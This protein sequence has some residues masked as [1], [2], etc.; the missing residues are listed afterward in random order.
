[1]QIAWQMQCLERER[2][3]RGKPVTLGWC[4]D[5]IVSEL[6]VQIRFGGLACR[7]RGRRSAL[8]LVVQ[9][10]WQGLDFRARRADFVGAVLWRMGRSALGTVGQSLPLPNSSPRQLRRVAVKASRE[11]GPCCLRRRHRGAS[12]QSAR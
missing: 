7:C 11:K 8:E 9:M 3:H 12:S 10:S 6:G 4:A 2:R 1:M 5:V